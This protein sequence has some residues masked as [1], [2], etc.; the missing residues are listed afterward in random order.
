MKKKRSKQIVC[1]L[2]GAGRI[3]DLGSAIKLY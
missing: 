2:A 3:Q 1:V